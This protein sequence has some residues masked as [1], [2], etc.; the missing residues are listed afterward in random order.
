MQFLTLCEKVTP[1]NTKY[2][3]GTRWQGNKQHVHTKLT[4]CKSGCY[5]ND[6]P[7]KCVLLFYVCDQSVCFDIFS[8]SLCI[9]A[10]EDH[11]CICQF[12]N[13]FGGGWTEQYELGNKFYSEDTVTLA[14]GGNRLLISNVLYFSIFAIPIETKY[15][16]QIYEQQRS[17]GYQYQCHSFS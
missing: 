11:H 14:D 3:L 4:L 15:A 17:P 16:S 12:S 9:D 1:I 7:L 13:D 2:G 6:I 5:D 10:E 8:Y